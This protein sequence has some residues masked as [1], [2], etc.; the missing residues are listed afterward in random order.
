MTQTDLDQKG[1]AAVSDELRGRLER[2]ECPRCT[3]PM[4][5]IEDQGDKRKQCTSYK[6]VVYDRFLNNHQTGA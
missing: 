5:R 2:N 4:A 3:S 6:M 1:F